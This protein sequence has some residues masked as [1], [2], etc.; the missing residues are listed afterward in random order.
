MK[1]LA[2]EDDAIY[3]VGSFQGSIDVGG[4]AL[5][6]GTGA[7]L[8][9]T[10]FD[11]SG[12]LVWATS[13]R[14]DETLGGA[15]VVGSADGGLLFGGPGV[16]GLSFGSTA[17]DVALDGAN[18]GWGFLVHYRPD[19]SVGFASTIAGTA[20]TGPD[21]ISR[22]GDRVYVDLVLRGAANEAAGRPLP[23]T[24]KDGAVWALDLV[25]RPT[26]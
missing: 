6:A 8:A 25:A 23:A 2:Y 5:D 9:V 3:A 19:G 10:R 14:A 11:P 18:G 26:G 21:E 20:N 7:D 12:D 16:P 13:V 24:G 4:E 17:G 22:S 1:G 15:E